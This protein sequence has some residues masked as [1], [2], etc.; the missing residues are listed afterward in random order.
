MNQP[1]V[2]LK[3]KRAAILMRYQ[4]PWVFS[5]GLLGKPKLD[6]GTLVRVTDPEDQ[7]VGWG[8]FHP[9]NTIALR[10]L[11]FGKGEM[12][13][14]F[15]KQ[16]IT[17]ALNMRTTLLNDRTNYRL[18]HGEHDGLPGLTVDRFGD[19]L[20]MQVTSAGMDLIKDT[21]VAELVSCTGV[22]AVYER[23]EGHAREQ[24]GLMPTRSFLHGSVDF[25]LE[26]TERGFTW[27][28]N[29][30]KDQKTGFYLDQHNQHDWVEARSQGKDVLDLCSYMGGF[31]LAALRGGAN[32]VRSLDISA[33]VLDLLGDALTA[34]GLDA[35]RHE[36]VKADVFSWIK[37]EPDRTYD[38]VVLDPPPLAKSLKAARNALKAYS[39]LQVD[40]A[41]WVKPGGTL[42]TFSCSGVINPDDFQQSVFLG[43]REAGREPMLISRFGVASDHP[44]NLRFPEGDYLKG[45]AMY[46]P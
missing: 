26:I 17:R 40:A 15:W 20:C 1:K 38:M 27:Q 35:E 34:N 18:I 13:P 32:H 29:P 14:D 7:Q 23:S 10:M 8:F 4:H 31:S 24:E 45:L 19:L 25:P 30:A 39:R 16:Q 2:S 5:K 46:L 3:A 36:A 11:S 9:S 41:K 28:M 12:Q 44:V 21:I 33:R 37:G 6:A 22:Q 43:L 42:L